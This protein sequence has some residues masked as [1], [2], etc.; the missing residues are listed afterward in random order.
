M[1]ASC[2]KLASKREIA[3]PTPSP[4][5]PFPFCKLGSS[6][7]IRTVES[8]GRKLALFF[9]PRPARFWMGSFFQFC[10]PDWLRSAKSPSIQKATPQLG[11]F[12]Q[13]ATHSP[14]SESAFGFVF[15]NPLA[16]W[17]RSAK[18]PPIHAAFPNWVRFFQIIPANWLRSAEC[19]AVRP[20]LSSS[21]VRSVPASTLQWLFPCV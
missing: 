12:F 6:F 2:T 17:L 16:H 4:S 5:L 7:Q 21:P 8:P 18:S 9:Q 15:S 19:L 20:A 10:P 14:R 13:L 11:S 3:A 1:P